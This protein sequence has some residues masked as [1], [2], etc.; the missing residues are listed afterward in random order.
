VSP[1]FLC[2]TGAKQRQSSDSTHHKSAF[3]C[4]TTNL[5]CFQAP[6][7]SLNIIQL[8]RQ[9][10]SLTA[11]IMLTTRWVRC[12]F[13]AASFDM[14]G[15]PVVGCNI[16]TPGRKRDF[17]TVCGTVPGQANASRHLV[18]HA[19]HHRR[20]VR[21]GRVTGTDH[22]I[23]AAAGIVSRCVTLHTSKLSLAQLQPLPAPSSTCCVRG[24]VRLVL[25]I[26]ITWLPSYGVQGVQGSAIS[27]P[28]P[29]A[30]WREQGRRR[31]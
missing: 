5:T 31:R 26:L 19:P 29:P 24:A 14:L 23:G 20:C 8:F 16:S 11:T 21:V 12:P 28:S 15:P 30:A 10:L 18:S 3:G 6:G 1:L 9:Q 25:V 17:I 7:L 4:R 13:I 22:G 27:P 2:R